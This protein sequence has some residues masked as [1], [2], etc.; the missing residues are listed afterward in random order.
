MPSITIDFTEFLKL[1]TIYNLKTQKITK[2]ESN[3][4]VRKIS[5]NLPAIY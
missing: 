4:S 1:N 5:K 3:Y 2:N